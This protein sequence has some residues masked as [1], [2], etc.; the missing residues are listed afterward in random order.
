M[1]FSPKLLTWLL[2]LTLGICGIVGH[3]SH[4]QILT[5]YNYYLLLS[6]FIVLAAGTTFRGL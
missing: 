5:P 6:G 4:V 2:G 3:Y 1:P